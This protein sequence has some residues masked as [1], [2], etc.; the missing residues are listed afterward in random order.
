MGVARFWYG[1]RKFEGRWERLRRKQHRRKKWGE[2][3]GAMFPPVPPS[4]RP[5]LKEAQKL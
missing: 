2:G 1:S 3:G 5:L 4:P